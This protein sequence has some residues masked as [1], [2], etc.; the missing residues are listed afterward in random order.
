[1]NPQKALPSKIRKEEMN[2]LIDMKILKNNRSKGKSLDRYFPGAKDHVPIHCCFWTLVKNSTLDNNNKVMVLG[3]G[4]PCRLG[5]GGIVSSSLGQVWYI[6]FSNKKENFSEQISNYSQADTQGHTYIWQK[7][8]EF[9]FQN[10]YI[11]LC[12]EQQ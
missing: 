6:F 7:D 5:R 12:A 9:E 8:K 10:K 1:M 3:S 2:L 4:G 11:R